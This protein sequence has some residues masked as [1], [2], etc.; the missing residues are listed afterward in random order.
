[1]TREST[2]AGGI[3]TTYEGVVDI[4]T[5]IGH[6]DDWAVRFARERSVQLED[7]SSVHH[8]HFGDTW[9]FAPCRG[10]EYIQYSPTRTTPTKSS[11]DSRTSPRGSTAVRL[12]RRASW[13]TPA[14][15]RRPNSTQEVK[16]PCPK[17]S[18]SGLQNPTDGGS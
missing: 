14:R 15:P 1:M 2:D 7:G 9:Y 4:I 18:G 3:V 13:G 8:G 16:L 11:T 5:D 6:P 12:R 17:L 10:P